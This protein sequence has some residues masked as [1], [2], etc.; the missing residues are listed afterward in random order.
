MK[1]V[2]HVVAVNRK[3]WTAIGGFLSQVRTSQLSVVVEIHICPWIISTPFYYSLI[4]GKLH[5][6]AWRRCCIY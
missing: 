2:D 5:L 6:G 3:Y 1:I 4:N